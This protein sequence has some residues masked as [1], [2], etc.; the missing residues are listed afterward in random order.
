MQVI[1]KTLI[2][3][4]VVLVTCSCG[5]TKKLSYRERLLLDCCY[6]HEFVDT[7]LKNNQDAKK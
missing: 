4:V 6:G 3:V 2:S 5:S 1:R 7:T